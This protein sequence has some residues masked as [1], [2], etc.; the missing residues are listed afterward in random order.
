LAWSFGLKGKTHWKSAQVGAEQQRVLE[1]PVVGHMSVV[2]F[3]LIFIGAVHVWLAQVGGMQHS[4]EV[5]ELTL[6]HTIVL[7]CGFGCLSAEH[8]KVAHVGFWQHTS[9]VQPT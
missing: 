2:G 8:E 7:K 9:F 4:L 3:C 5:Q 1:Q 6:A